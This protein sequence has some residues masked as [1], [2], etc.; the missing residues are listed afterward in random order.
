MQEGGQPGL[1]P[2]EPR[3][4]RGYRYRSAF[5]GVVIVAVGVVLLLYNLE[6]ISRE[7]LAM[8]GLL[9]PILLVGIGVDLLVGRRSWALGGLV[10]VV[11]V[12]LIIVLML[13][14]PSAGWIGDTELKTETVSAPLCQATSAKVTVES[15]QYGADIH[16]LPASAEA[17]RPLV[18]AQVTYQ[19]TLDFQC[20]GV[21][22]RVV[23]IKTTGHRWW[24]GWLDSADGDPW[25][26]GIDPGIPLDLHLRTSSGPCEADLTGLRLT[27][28]A[29][30]MSSG[31]VEVSL[32]AF[33][34]PRCP[35]RLEM[36]SGDFELQA[37]DESQIDMNV[38]MSSGDA[39][40]TLGSD[41][42]ATVTFDGSSGEFSLDVASGQALRVE[43][44]SVSSGDIDLPP[45]LTQV[46]EGDDEEGTW[47][48]DGYDAASHKVLVII[49][50]MSSG[51]V[52]IRLR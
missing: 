13:A 1:T 31:A 32:P 47:E 27:G 33:E 46:A 50:H 12:G 15:S 25:E 35:V 17:G 23:S 49:E 21:E 7:S 19:G 20:S 36:S 10:G 41:C 26:I 37:P 8:L 42:D 18:I 9:W 52:D 40:V 43:V 24:W 39:H 2:A 30:D 5:W 22:S 51:D 29:V 11:T 38:D 6:V 3:P 44:R 4:R 14:G 48:T 34:G 28:L 45:A 16:A